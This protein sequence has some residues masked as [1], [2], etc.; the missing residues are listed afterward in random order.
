MIRLAENIGA[1]ELAELE[2]AQPKQHRLLRT[3]MELG[4]AIELRDLCR[5]LNLSD[6]PA[7]T[8]AKNGLVVIERVEA[9][10]DPLE[11]A[12]SG[13]TR[14]ERLSERQQTA[15]A[16]LC[17]PLERGEHAAFLLEGVT[18]S[19]KTEVYLAAIERALALGKSSIVL[20]P[21]IALTP[22]TVGWF[23]SRFERVAVLHSRMTDL[24][25]HDMWLQ[26]AR[27][28][29]I[30]VVGARSA[31]FAP[32]TS[33]GVVVVDE[34]H[35]PS[36]K[37]GSTPRYHAR[38]V[39]LERARLANAVC[40]LGSATPA[41]ESWAAA[42]AGRLAHLRLPERAT[43]NP[44]PPVEVLDLKSERLAPTPSRLFSVR[45]IEALRGVLARKEQAI[46]FLN[47]RGFAPVLWCSGCK[48][49]VRCKRCDVTLVFHRRIQRL[50][51]HLC[52]EELP[53][54][55]S[56]PTCTKPNLRYLSAGAERI[57]QELGD[58]FDGARVQRMDS[59]TMRRREDYERALEA[60]GRGEIDVL[61]GT[62]MIAK[63]LDFPRV[64]LVGIISAD[65][66]LYLPD[67][68]AAERTFQLI[69]QVAGRAGRGELAGKI[70]VQTHSPEHASIVRAARHDFEGF[71]KAECE[72]RAELGYP[73]FGRL[74]RAFFE[75]PSEAKVI[76]AA[77]SFADALRA[78]LA[79]PELSALA[80][81]I[82]LLGPAPA[83]ISMARGKFRHHVLIKTPIEGDAFARVRELALELT[84]SA[85]APQIGRAHV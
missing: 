21:E 73:P 75:D 33:L 4:G 30:V 26:V 13:R 40:V 1:R 14:P 66:A 39:A 55:Q 58:V 19:G 51:C 63:G 50:V 25:R 48:E 56:C 68:R 34:E 82:A 64:T 60:F 61:V 28:G 80:L 76:D 42:R 16:A 62:Q 45:L 29:P 20:V 31:I 43:S 59:D 22:Q 67:F 69:A 77:R 2:A 9:V 36:F 57:E 49:T 3:L 72:L 15:V 10:R 38:D 11:F 24:Q 23:R 12:K 46:L 54:V 47:R 74:L 8:L 27:G 79:A 78:R 7:R 52:C 44:L 18:G 35:E 41:L 83:P 70:V 6:A 32:V 5:Q 85:A 71:A 37:Q 65:S 53:A 17:A 84:E 81:K